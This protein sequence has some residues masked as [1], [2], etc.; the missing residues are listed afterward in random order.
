MK[1]NNLTAKS[2]L[3]LAAPHTWIAS[4]G[5]VLFGILFC[6]LEKY[7]LSFWKSIILVLTCIFMQSSVNT[8][9]DYVDYI[10]GNDS[11]KDNVEESDAVLVYNPINP[12]HVL[13]LAIVYL[14]LGVVLGIIACRDSGFLPLGIGCIGGAVILLYSG[15][16][17]PISYLPIG[18]I[19]S[20]FVMGILIPLGV[21]AVSDGK[22]HSEIL[23]YA[24]PLMIGIALIMMTNNGCDIEKDTLANRQTLAVIL[25]RRNTK[26]LYH[27]LIVIWLLI[28]SFLS[29]Y[30]LGNVGFITPVLIA[31]GYR[32]FKSLMQSEL[33]ASKRIEQMKNIVK[34]NIIVNIAYFIAILTKII[35]EK[36]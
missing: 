4:I 16:P 23:V 22:F 6:K 11:E 25:E 31:L 24:F 27:V 7:P 34:A 13:I 15:G 20:G 33:L 2:A 36:M 21:V 18:E 12:K 29:V 3:Q 30:L 17:L 32:C 28:I 9:N 10:K 8:F 26:N 5:P 1:T 19:V 14:I 35:A